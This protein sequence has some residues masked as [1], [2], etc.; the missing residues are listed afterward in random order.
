MKFKIVKSEI[1]KLMW[2]WADNWSSGVEEGTPELA[3]HGAKSLKP[4]H[5]T[6]TNLRLIL[7]AVITSCCTI[8]T[9]LQAVGNADVAEEWSKHVW[10]VGSDVAGR[11]PLWRVLI[12]L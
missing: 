5:T 6:G 3:W 9:D 7:V 2:L 11:L 8:G 10:L 4:A 12:G 1:E